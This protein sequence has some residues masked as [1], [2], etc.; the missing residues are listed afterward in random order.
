MQLQAG[1]FPIL[2]EDYSRTV[3]VW[4][5]SVRATHHFVCEADI[6]FFRPLVRDALPQMPESTVA[7]AVRAIEAD[8]NAWRPTLRQADPEPAADGTWRIRHS[9]YRREALPIIRH[10][11]LIREPGAVEFVHS[12]QSLIGGLCRAGFVV[13]D[14]TEPMH[15]DPAAPTGSFA[16][17]CSFLPP[18]VRIKARRSGTPVRPETPPSIWTP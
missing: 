1:V 10:D 4:E 8:A 14:L 15:C 9:N 13:E 5:A 11:N 3:D 2:A 7:T 6:Q 17:R 18:Y 12:W 16:H